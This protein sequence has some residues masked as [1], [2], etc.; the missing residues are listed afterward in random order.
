[1]VATLPFNSKPATLVIRADAGPRIGHGHFMRCLALGQAWRDRGGEVQF[2]T[3]CSNE[4]LLSYLD[5]EDFGV[6]QLENAYPATCDSKATR[7]LMKSL[8]EGWLVIDGYHFDCAYEK[9]V[10]GPGWR[11][12]IVDDTATDRHYFP[13]VIFNQNLHAPKLHYACE[14]E[15]KL[16]L[17][18]K[19]ILLRREFLEWRAWRRNIPEKARKVLVT[20][21]GSDPENTTS[22]VIRALQASELNGIEATIVAGANNPRFGEIEDTIRSS[23]VQA[24][25][26]QEAKMPELMA[27]A[28]VAISGAGST[29]WEL[30][31]LGTPALVLIASENQAP[32]AAELDAAGVAKS[33]GWQKAVSIEALTRELASLLADSERRAEMSR[34]GKELV[35]GYGAE[36]VVMALRGVRLRLRPAEEG[37]C[38]LLWHWANEPEVRARSFSTAAIPWEDHRAW[39]ARKLADRNCRIFIGFNDQ[40]QPVG[41]VR[42]EIDPNGEAEVGVSIAKTHRGCGYGAPLLAAAAEELV[43][44]SHVRTIHAFVKPDN[45]SSMRAFEKA[46]FTCHGDTTEKGEHALHY[47]LGRTA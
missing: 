35:D 34:R 32:I 1:M 19:Y 18:A 15:T 11:L 38:T 4:K 33:L 45:P 27:W 16:L 3:A 14:R 9:E 36:R 2:I 12:M 43:R 31:F 21:G 5:E 13:D 17:G 47:S 20:L 24:R 41:Q 26:V 40:D 42:F 44:S 46:S 8:P 23:G 39:F 37:D 7:E 30:A 22:K 6:I 10:S 28:D 29:C 25:L